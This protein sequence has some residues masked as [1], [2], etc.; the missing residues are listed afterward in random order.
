PCLELVR[1]RLSEGADPDAFVAG[2]PV[3]TEWASRQPGF[4][5]R[6]LVESGDGGWVDMIWWASE[7]EALAAADNVMK[8]L[9]GTPFMMMIDPMTVE[10]GH[11]PIAHMSAA[12]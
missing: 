1:F 3:V 7:T 2:A 10:I 12:A 4:Q 5:R 6:T 8:D 9:G 11:H